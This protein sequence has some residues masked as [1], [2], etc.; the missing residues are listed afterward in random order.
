MITFSSFYFCKSRVLAIVHL[1]IS[2]LPHGEWSPYVTE[3]L[4]N[5][6]DANL[7]NVGL[8]GRLHSAC[9]APLPRVIPLL[10]S[11][12]LGKVRIEQGRQ[13]D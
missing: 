2:A 5:L 3:H 8:H 10:L 6:S 11:K 9:T 12:Y 1:H 7:R 4:H 13:G